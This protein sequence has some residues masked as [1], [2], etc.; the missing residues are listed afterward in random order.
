MEIKEIKKTVEQVVRT[1]YVAMDGTVFRNERECK[2]YEESALCVVKSKLK[3]LK[4]TTTYDLLWEGSEEEYIDIINVENE[5]DLD[6]LKQY[7]YLVIT[8]KYVQ[9]GNK[10]AKQ[11]LDEELNK[12][13][14]GHEVLLQWSYD[15]L[16]YI[17]GNGSF[18][19]YLGRIRDNYTKLI[20]PKEEKANA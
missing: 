16:A 13:T 17:T 4:R 12:I 15:D 9:N 10:Y 8:S 18:E 11:C 19:D 7:V 2:A 14:I 20:S 3:L 1:E 6:N 5:Q